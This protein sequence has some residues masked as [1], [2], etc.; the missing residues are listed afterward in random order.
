MSNGKSYEDY[1]VYDFIMDESFTRGVKNPESGEGLFWRAYYSDHPAKRAL[2]DEAHRIITSISLHNDQLPDNQIRDLLGE[3][4]ERIDESERHSTVNVIQPARSA[5]RFLSIWQRVAAVSIG[6]LFVAATLILLIIPSKPVAYATHYGETKTI[7]LPDGS[8]VI[9]N[10]NSTLE[11]SPDFSE[12]DIREVRLE[13]E[14]FFSVVHTTDDQKFNVRT[15]DLNVEVLGTEFNVNSR[16]GATKVVL[17]SGKVQLNIGSLPDNADKLSINENTDKTGYAIIMRPGDLVEYSDQTK[18]ITREEVN[19]ET[20][21]SWKDNMLVFEDTPV[22]EIVRILEDN[23]GF[24]VII[25][26]ALTTRKFTAS[27][28]TDDIDVI[29]KALSR[30]FN[31]RISRTGEKILFQRNGQE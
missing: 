15:S 30:S 14:A 8:S 7:V 12:L 10:A 24:E 13:G 5:H 19:P 20:F 17:N 21:T 16:R 22:S 28:S 2:I 4:N 1:T 25:D 29:L 31:V 9:L 26:S 23:Y 3:L 27:Y 6:I 18:R 11:H